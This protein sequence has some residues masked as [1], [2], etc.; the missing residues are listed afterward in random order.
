MGD[1]VVFYAHELVR[2]EVKVLVN[3]VGFFQHLHTE[4][5]LED[6]HLLQALVVRIPVEQ[7]F[8]CEHF[9]DRAGSRPDVN[10]ESQIP[11]WRSDQHTNEELTQNDLRSSIVARD[12]LCGPRNV[13]HRHGISEINQFALFLVLGDHHVVGLDIQVHDSVFVDVEETHEDLVA[14]GPYCAEAEPDPLPEHRN[15]V[16]HVETQKFAH[17]AEMLAVVEL[18]EEANDV[19]LIKEVIVVQQADG[20]PF[21][22]ACSRQ[23]FGISRDLKIKTFP[24]RLP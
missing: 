23:N 18:A 10:A 4:G 24:I 7:K 17:D 14:V 16:A 15:R 11:P 22:F 20:V 19:L 3:K 9:I 5:T 8:A 6:H 12:K 1:F 21:F 2:V 13:I